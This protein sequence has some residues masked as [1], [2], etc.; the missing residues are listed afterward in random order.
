MKY[1]RLRSESGYILF[2]IVILL[3][4]LGI[5]LVAAVPLWQ[6]AVQREREQELIF[7]GYQYMQ[8]IERYQ[9]KYP[10]A[11]PPSIDVL[12]EQKF[13]RKAYKDPL[14]GK[15]GEWNLLR[16]LSPELSPGQQQ[17]QQAGEAAGINA[18]NRSRAQL[19]TPG[20][21]TPG[22]QGTPSQTGR[23]FQSS[24]GR[25]LSDASLGGIVGVASRSKEKTFY[26]VPGKETYKDWLFVWGVQQPGVPGVPVPGQASPSPFPGLPPPPR[27]TSF[28]FGAAPMPGQQPPGIGRPGQGFPS[29]P[30]QPGF[31]PPGEPRPGQPGFGGPR[32]QRPSGPGFGTPP[33]QPQPPRQKRQPD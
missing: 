3:V 9:R 25:G 27:L 16:Q 22:T 23:E 29:P 10:G 5:S 15:D 17:L 6:K 2:G 19:R 26:K 12:V 21:A 7:R 13:L 14:G 1:G 33:A 4:I 18:L 32:E 11:Y 8:A 28:G 31:G 20:G 24:L 30:G